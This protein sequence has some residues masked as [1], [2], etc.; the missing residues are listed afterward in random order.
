MQINGDFEGFLHN[1]A[2]LYFFLG[3]GFNHFFYFHLDPWGNDPI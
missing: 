2:L 1:S 3:G